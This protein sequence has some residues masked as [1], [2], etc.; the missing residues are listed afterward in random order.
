VFGVQ[1]TE[2]EAVSRKGDPGTGTQTTS[3]PIVIEKRS[4]LGSS[5]KKIREKGGDT[6]KKEGFRKET[7][8]DMLFG[9]D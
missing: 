2:K 8:W 5:Q 3:F 4:R 6:Q 9:G 1:L 7:T